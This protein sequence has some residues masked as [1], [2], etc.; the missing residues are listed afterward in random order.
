[1]TVLVCLAAGACR[2]H[3]TYKAVPKNDKPLRFMEFLRSRIKG[4][5]IDSFAQIA[6]ERIIKAELNHGEKQ[7][8]M[9]IRLWSNAANI[10]VTDPGVRN[11]AGEEL[12]LDVFYRRPNKSE[13]SG[14]YYKPQ[15]R[16]EAVPAKQW[17]VRTFDE[18]PDSE[19]LSFN[20]KVEKWYSENAAAL[21]RTALL[22]Q[23]E[24]QYQSR[25][26]RLEAAIERL[27]AKRKT[28]LHAE[29][30]KHFGDLILT[31]GQ[32]VGEAIAKNQRNVECD[33]Y[34]TGSKICIEIDPKKNVQENA[35]DYYDRYKKAV[36]GI[37]D[38][39]YD[40]KSSKSELA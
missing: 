38:L 13:V 16:T 24:K 12:I 14:G 28:F 36:S 40:I 30:W 1:K 21:S 5:R 31:W 37:E 18:L 23:A 4:C 15:I 8:N 25:K 10:I 29:R 20:E 27:E 35:A 39:E 34:E 26:S 11:D 6:Q 22:E 3:E 32:E 2:I 7:F 9:Y 19:N 17:T 33:D